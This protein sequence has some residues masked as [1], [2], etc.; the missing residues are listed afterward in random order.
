MS[1]EDDNKK[2]P[3]KFSLSSDRESRGDTC[4]GDVED[5]EE[6][7]IHDGGDDGVTGDDE[8]EENDEDEADGLE[9]ENLDNQDDEDEG[10]W[11]RVGLNR[12]LQDGTAHDLGLSVP[13]KKFFE[14]FYE[15]YFQ[16][17]GNTCSKRILLPV[18]G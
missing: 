16:N 6:D 14:R 18:S 8:A 2:S 11:G 15:K 1:A 9:E 13:C 7:D 12:L 5:T 10:G 4:D 17:G 3:I